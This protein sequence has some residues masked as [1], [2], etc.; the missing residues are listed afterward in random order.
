MQKNSQ[1][2]LT[3][4][5]GGRLALKGANAGTKKEINKIMKF[6][7]CEDPITHK[8][9]PLLDEDNFKKAKQPLPYYYYRS[10]MKYVEPTY[11]NVVRKLRWTPEQ[12]EGMLSIPV[13]MSEKQWSKLKDEEKIQLHANQCLLAGETAVTVD[14]F[15]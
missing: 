2:L 10:H 15:V 13:G 7:G 4:V 8:W 9:G 3:F 6:R 5:V 14:L 1:A 12:V 11:Y